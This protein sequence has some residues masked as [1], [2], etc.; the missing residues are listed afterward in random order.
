V[1]A[2]GRE[3]KTPFALAKEDDIRALLKNHGAKE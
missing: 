2:K 3:G 1:N